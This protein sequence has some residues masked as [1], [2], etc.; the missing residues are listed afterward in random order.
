M[1]SAAGSVQAVVTSVDDEN[2]LLHAAGHL[3]VDGRVIY[4]MQDF[5]LR[6][7]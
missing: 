5:T 4:S 6:V 2:R 3:S 7:R 1:P